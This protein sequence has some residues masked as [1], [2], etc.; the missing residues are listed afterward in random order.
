M[1]PPFPSP[2]SPAPALERD[3]V[4]ENRSVDIGRCLG[5]AWTLLWSD[6]WSI[7]GVTLLA[8][9]L[10]VVALTTVVGVVVS[11]PLVGGLY[12]YFLKKVRREP[13]TVSTLFAG[14]SH[15]FLPLFL[16]GLVMGLLTLLGLLCLIL[17]G[18]YL[19]VGWMF[20]LVLIMDKQLGFWPAMGLSR[21]VISRHWGKFF[22]FFL[23]LLLVNLLGSI[24][25]LVGTFVTIPLTLAALLFAY[26]DIFGEPPPPTVEAGYTVSSESAT[27]KWVGLGVVGLVIGLLVI[28]GWEIH[29]RWQI[30]T[31][32]L[33]TELVL[34]QTN[35]PAETVAPSAPTDETNSTAVAGDSTAPTT[36][37]PA[38]TQ[39]PVPVPVPASVSPAPPEIPSARI[40]SAD[41][42]LSLLNS[43][44]R[45]VLEY[46]D[47]KFARFADDR[48]FDG[49]TQADRNALE[50]KSLDA[51][52]GPRNDDYF[53]AINTLAAL[54]S[55]NALPQLRKLALVPGPKI[56]RVEIS[57]RPR[58]LTIR[59]ISLI[60]DQSAVPEIIHLL[61]HNNSYVRWSAQL[62]LVRLTGQNFGK[63]WRAWGNWW[64]AQGGQPRF[65]PEMVRWWS[66]QLE[67][68]ALARQQA[69]GDQAFLKT[70]FGKKSKTRPDAGREVN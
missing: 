24:I 18:V 33:N 7:L 14:F 35:A 41:T 62:A 29:H 10:R 45:Q 15:L 65:N 69:E 30:M 27:G 6:F 57:N 19:M 5:R 3:Y 51:L 49:W 13:V 28:G 8:L 36:V 25:F 37:A 55:T 9:L 67:P 59:A 54:R 23:V 60:G 16:G 56:V 11:T 50:K 70:V 53:Q 38:P 58:W 39:A 32:N 4:A 42:M 20:T 46:C 12:F 26:E 64:N 34:G 48:T 21:K 17:P 44:Q 43:N 40:V 2:P 22:G 61:Y 47:V 66:G 68:Y 52:K 63:D 31:Q 1:E